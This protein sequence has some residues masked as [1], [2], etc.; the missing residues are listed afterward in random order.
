MS[1]INRIF[2]LCLSVLFFTVSICAENI[3]V[4]GQIYSIAEPDLLIFIHARLLQYQQDGKLLSMESDFKKRVQESVLRPQPV[5]DVS[6]ALPSDKTIVKYYTPSVTLQHNIIN[7]N[8]VI[9]FY[10]GTV[11]NPLDVAAVQKI[12][13]NAVIPS[14]H[15][16]LLFIDADN[17]SQISFAKKKIKSLLKNNPFAIY[18]IILTKGNLKT[19]SNTLGRIY[20]DQAGVLCRLFG[21]T[22]VPAVVVKSGIRLKITEPAI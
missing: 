22:R 1:K 6:D 14:F 9:L 19:A 3:G 2:I 18:K 7:Q 16:T 10:K 20:F 4:Y 21:I 15:E 5:S 11:I 12:A 17:A 8:G 13:P